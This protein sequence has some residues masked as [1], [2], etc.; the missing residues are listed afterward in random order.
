MYLLFLLMLIGFFTA[1]LSIH[2]SSFVEQTHS[3]CAAAARPRAHSQLRT[4]TRV[5]PNNERLVLERNSNKQN[6]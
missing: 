1:F 2:V 5:G 3:N 6:N 4:R